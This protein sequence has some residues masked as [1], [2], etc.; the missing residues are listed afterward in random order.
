M[1]SLE[2]LLNFFKDHIGQDKRLIYQLFRTLI[3][4]KKDIKTVKIFLEKYGSD[5]LNQFSQSHQDFYN[6][7]I[8]IFLN[9]E[10]YSSQTNVNTAEY[11]NPGEFKI[12]NVV[13]VDNES[14]F[15]EMISY[16]DSHKI[17]VIGK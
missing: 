8:T 3:E 5:W 17:D 15:E 4:Y 2:L 6:K 16:F 13:F 12:E 11:Y 14:K 9:N 1:K 10:K 7:N